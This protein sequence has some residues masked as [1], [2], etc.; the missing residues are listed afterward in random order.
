VDVDLSLQEP[1]KPVEIRAVPH[2]TVR[3]QNVDGA[4]KPIPGREVVLIGAV[5]S[6]MD[7]QIKGVPDEQG[8]I[9]M[10]VPKGVRDVTLII[11][12]DQSHAMRFRQGKDGALS[13]NTQPRLGTLDE[14]VNDL[15]VVYYQ[16]PVVVVRVLGPNGTAVKD[17]TVSARY[18]PPA[19][20]GARMPIRNP[21]FFEQQAD[22][23]WRSSG[24]LPD[25]EFAL[26]VQAKG[27]PLNSQTLKLAEGELREVEVRLG[28]NGSQPAR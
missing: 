8:A 19:V 1:P 4:G 13:D 14:D 6:K 20:P 3:V 27:L 2:V 26:G 16:A 7:Y 18:L 22:G 17:C 23:R 24:I 5:K 11:S 28:P 21:P 9:V 12:G 25:E 10:L 15:F